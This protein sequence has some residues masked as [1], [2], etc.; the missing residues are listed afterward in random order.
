MPRFLVLQPNNSSVCLESFVYSR[1]FHDLVHVAIVHR[2]IIAAMFT[3]N[4]LYG[5]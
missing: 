4:V 2:I 5:V 3:E 1:M